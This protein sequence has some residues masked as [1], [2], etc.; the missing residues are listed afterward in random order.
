M[1]DDPD[2]LWGN[3]ANELNAAY[4][5]DGYARV[6]GVGALATTFGVGE[7]SAMNG[8]AGS[9]SEMVPVIHIVGTPNTA[10]QAAGAILHHTLGNGDFD[11]FVNMFASVTAASVHITHAQAARQIDLVISESVRRRRPGKINK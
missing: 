6:K 1:I 4:A 2:L 8:I 9:Y 11:V 5:A 3:N 7:L 10:S